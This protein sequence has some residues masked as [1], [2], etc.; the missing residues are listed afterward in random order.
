M[1][2]AC[3]VPS[4]GLRGALNNTSFDLNESHLLAGKTGIDTAI[5]NNIFVNASVWYIDTGVHTTVGTFETSIDSIAYMVGL[6]YK[7]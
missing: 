5:N 4:H 3:L 1:I 7:I 2:L 6:G